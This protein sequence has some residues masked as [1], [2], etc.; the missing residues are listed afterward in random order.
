MRCRVKKN[1]FE[2]CLHITLDNLLHKNCE[3][4]LTCPSSHGHTI[5]L[6]FF[7]WPRTKT[8]QNNNS[9]QKRNIVWQLRKSPTRSI[10]SAI[11]KKI[12]VW[13][14]HSFET[15]Q[16]FSL[17]LTHVTCFSFSNQLFSISQIILSFQF[18]K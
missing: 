3:L 10:A 9:I 12:Y 18:F 15:C 13:D 6:F 7:I 5:I 2:I 17:S 1:L 16:V 11:F 4:A 8:N 14:K